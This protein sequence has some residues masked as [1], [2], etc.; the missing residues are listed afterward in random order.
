MDNEDIDIENDSAEAMV[1]DPPGPSH[2]FDQ[3][4]LAHRNPVAVSCVRT[5]CVFL[6]YALIG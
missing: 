6:N 1:S 4:H 2:S 5:T 3:E